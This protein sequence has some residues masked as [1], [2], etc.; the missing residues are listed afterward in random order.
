MKNSKRAKINPY[1]LISILGIVFIFAI[2]FIRKL[3]I[4]D[5]KVDDILLYSFW[6]LLSI[7]IL[8]IIVLSVSKLSNN[9]IAN[10]IY[11][12]IFKNLYGEIL[13]FHNVESLIY[14]IKSF[15]INRK[16]RLD[17]KA[18][19]VRL[20]EIVDN[21]YEINAFP[22]LT[23]VLTLMYAVSIYNN[24]L[25]VEYNTLGNNFL[26]V[27]LNL[28]LLFA[29]IYIITLIYLKTKISLCKLCLNIITEYQLIEK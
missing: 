15:Y 5:I 10:K 7:N 27:T 8:L 13:D 2:F 11:E 16:Q 6:F 20:N 17:L 1:I 23:F 29:F 14:T 4:F 19:R 18:E 9:F 3:E 21:S 25:N 26:F 22:V 24:N 12:Q 28:T